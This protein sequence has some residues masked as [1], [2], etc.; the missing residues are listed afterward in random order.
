MNTC[1]GCVT[2]WTSRSLCHC[3]ACHAS[4]R[5]LG[6]FDLH[7]RGGVCADPAGITGKDGEAVLRLD[8]RGIWV[9]AKARPTY[10]KKEA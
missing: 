6:G 10:W 9:G 7:R 2:R 3:G 1:G 8:D 4:F 5:T